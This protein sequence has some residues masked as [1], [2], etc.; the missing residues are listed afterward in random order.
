MSWSIY[1]TILVVSHRFINCRIKI[2]CTS[3]EI[4]LSHDILGSND[5]KLGFP[6]TINNFRAGP[7]QIIQYILLFYPIPIENNVIVRTTTCLDNIKQLKLSQ[8]GFKS[9]IVCSSLLI[10][11]IFCIHSVRFSLRQRISYFYTNTYIIFTK[12]QSFFE[13]NYVLEP[14]L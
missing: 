8:R 11:I 14:K 13:K 2:I 12:K 6:N 9:Q 3:P 7:Q 1:S 10:K 5:N 4:K